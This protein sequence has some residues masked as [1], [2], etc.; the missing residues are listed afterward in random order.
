MSHLGTVLAHFLEMD[1]ASPRVVAFCRSKLLFHTL[2]MILVASM[3]CPGTGCGISFDMVDLVDLNLSLSRNKQSP[4][5]FID[6]FDFQTVVAVIAATAS[7]R[8]LRFALARTSSDQTLSDNFVLVMVRAADFMALFMSS[9]TLMEYLSLS[10]IL[11]GIVIGQAAKI[12]PISKPLAK[13]DNRCGGILKLSREMSAALVL[14]ARASLCKYGNV[15]KLESKSTPSKLISLALDIRFVPIL[16]WH[17]FFE[18]T[19]S[20][21]LSLFNTKPALEQ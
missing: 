1:L 4:S 7:L 20:W 19:S 6:C 12:L 15:E 10:L 16:I 9:V 13:V 18:D 8:H 14:A 5:G 3:G 2:A 17:G 11:R 21:V